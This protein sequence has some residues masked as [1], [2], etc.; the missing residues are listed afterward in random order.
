MVQLQSKSIT[1]TW[2]VASWDEYLR[3][4]EDPAYTKVKSYYVNGQMRIET[5]GVDPDH[6]GDNGIIYVAITLFCALKG[7]PIKGFI[8]C[9]AIK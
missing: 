6:A 5:V 8:N 4:T 9:I 7:I 3:L 1:N 2:V